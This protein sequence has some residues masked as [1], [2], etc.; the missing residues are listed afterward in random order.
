VDPDPCT[1][2]Q[3]APSP[4]AF[5]LALLVFGLRRRSRAEMIDALATSGRLPADVVDR[6]R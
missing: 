3:G 2:R 4:A 6:L 5:L 1:C